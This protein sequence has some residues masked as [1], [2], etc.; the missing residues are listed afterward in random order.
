MFDNVL[1]DIFR[2]EGNHLLVA[3]CGKASFLSY[4]TFYVVYET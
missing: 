2:M 1:Q 3:S 4:F